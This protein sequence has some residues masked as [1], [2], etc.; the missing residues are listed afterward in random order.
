MVR[1]NQA[2]RHCLERGS[3]ISAT[4]FVVDSL[5]KK[6]Y[7][8]RAG[9][10]PVLLYRATDKQAEY[11]VDK[12][13]ALGMVKGKDYAKIVETNVLTYSPGDV[14]VLF[15]DGITEAKSPK[16]EE[17]G[18]ALLKKTIVE[19]VIRSPREIQDHLIKK[20]YTYTGTEEIDDDYTTMIV[21]FL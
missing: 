6:I 2:L 5:E 15:T 12:G 19:V 13:A 1:A 14:M 8:S 9:H 7:Y 18:L 11:L 20:L 17:F 10:C 3:F 16:G 4:Y 21:K